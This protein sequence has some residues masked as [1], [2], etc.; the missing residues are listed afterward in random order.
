MISWYVGFHLL[1]LTHLKRV[2]SK[3]VLKYI[4]SSS[5]LTPLS[6]VNLCTRRWR[7][8]AGQRLLPHLLSTRNL[9][10]RYVLGHHGTCERAGFRIGPGVCKPQLESFKARWLAQCDELELLPCATFPPVQKLLRVAVFARNCFDIVAYLCSMLSVISQA[11]HS[12]SL[13]D[14]VKLS[15]CKHLRLKLHLNRS[16]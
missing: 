15:E 3:E 16:I 13:E 7:Q 4:S 8:G 12:V 9:Q 2:L 10:S 6:Q 14:A 11:P 1:T 5:P